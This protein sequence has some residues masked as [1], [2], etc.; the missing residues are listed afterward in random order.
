MG[1]IIYREYIVFQGSDISCSLDN[2][3]TYTPICAHA[4]TTHTH[5][6]TRTHTH[7]NTHARTHVRTHTQSH[8]LVEFSEVH[9]DEQQHLREITQTLSK[10]PFEACDYFP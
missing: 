2:N 5:T 9:K 10:P 3:H 8:T 4:H 1:Q 7:T 6:H